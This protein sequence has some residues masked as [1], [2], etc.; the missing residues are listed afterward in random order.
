M[1]V[2]HLKHSVGSLLGDTET[3][4]KHILARFRDGHF[5]WRYRHVRWW[6]CCPLHPSSLDFQHLKWLIFDRHIAWAGW[7]ELRL[8]ADNHAQL[9]VEEARNRQTHVSNRCCRLQENEE[10]AVQL[11]MG[12]I[13]DTCL[14]RGN[15]TDWSVSPGF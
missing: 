9:L 7:E 6:W 15:V 4:A 8:F 13:A 14:F 11:R 5:M 2:T 1:K 10:G 12:L 3:D